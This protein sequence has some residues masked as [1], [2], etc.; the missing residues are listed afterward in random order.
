M[1][2]SGRERESQEQLN[3]SHFINLIKIEIL[4]CRYRGGGQKQILVLSLKSV[5][6]SLVHCE[7]CGSEDVL[8][9]VCVCVCVCARAF[10]VRRMWPHV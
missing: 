1:C 6:I 2:V 7:T 9:C 4:S 3:E 10:T 5:I 8:Q